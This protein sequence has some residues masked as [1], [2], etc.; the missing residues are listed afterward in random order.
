MLGVGCTFLFGVL[1]GVLAEAR[2]VLGPA[3]H[4]LLFTTNSSSFTIFSSS[5][6]SLLS[7][8][9]SLV[10]TKQPSSSASSPSDCR[11]SQVLSMFLQ[12]KTIWW[13]GSNELNETNGFTRALKTHSCFWMR[14]DTSWADFLLEREAAAV[15]T[16]ES[17]CS[18]SALRAKR[19]ESNQFCS[20]ATNF[21]THTKLSTGAEP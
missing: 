3:E 13:T 4:L 15:C 18:S 20:N 21:L 5:S 7:S 6:S 11:S 9:S 16:G 2:G 1:R 10:G 12:H 17:S 8:R 19:S 14:E